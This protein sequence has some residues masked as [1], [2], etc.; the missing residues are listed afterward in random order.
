MLSKTAQNTAFKV[1]LECKTDDQRLPE[2]DCKV[3]PH[4]LTSYPDSVSRARSWMRISLA[5]LRSSSASSS[6]RIFARCSSIL[7]AI[8]S[9]TCRDKVAIKSKHPVYQTD[10]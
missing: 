9:L 7:V 1:F 10:N 5:R 3:A 6:A 4:L 8:S 2:V